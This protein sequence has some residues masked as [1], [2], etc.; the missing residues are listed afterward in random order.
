VVQH[1]QFTKT[2]Y[3]FNSSITTGTSANPY[4]TTTRQTVVAGGIGA[5]LPTLTASYDALTGLSSGVSNGASADQKAYDDFGRIDSYTDNSAA[6]GTQINTTTTTYDPTHGWVTQTGD[7]HSITAYTYDGGTEHRRL[8]TSETATVAGASSY[9][10][11]FTAGYNADGDLITQTDPN[12]VT[13]TLTRNEAAQP[14]RTNRDASR[15]CVADR[16]RHAFDK[17]TVALA[18]WTC[19]IADLPIRRSRETHT[20]PRHR[21]CQHLRYA[22]LQLRRRQQ[23]IVGLRLPCGV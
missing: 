3:G 12:G 11:T 10:G 15:R 21:R 1:Q 22:Y 16:R 20:S 18:R 6:T 8:V 2:I 17:W 13:T 23:S 9:T 19:R 14:T 7:A 4:A 5:V